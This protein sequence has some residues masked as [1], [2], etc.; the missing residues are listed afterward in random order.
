ME[1]L[2]L[3]G[4]EI[5]PVKYKAYSLAGDYI[6]VQNDND[7]KELYDINGNK[8]SNLNYKS[9]Q[10]SGNKGSYIAID[11]NGFYSIITEDETFSGNYTYA[12][13]AFDDYFIF[14]NQEGFYGLI[15]IYNRN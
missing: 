13:Y 6:S 11:D 12:S 14:K 3:N 2:V 15:D 4:K 7:L 9:I 8:V 5:L 10:S 1:F